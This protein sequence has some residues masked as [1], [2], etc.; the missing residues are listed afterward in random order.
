MRGTQAPDE[1]PLTDADRTLKVPVLGICG[2]EQ[3]INISLGG[4]L[5]QDIKCLEFETLEHEQLNPRN[6]T[7]HQI[8]IEPKT[9]LH[10]IIGENEISVNSAHHQAIDKLGN[11]LIMSS[12]SKDGIIESIE[13]SIHK[14][15]VGL[16]WHPEFLITKADKLIF[17][18]FIYN[19]V[20]K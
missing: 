10:K 2:G 4:T 17:L 12:M 13:S 8:Y 7:S 9:L 5:I 16:Q 6:Q 18:D 14:W 19:S 11:N 1:D 20:K 15:C 3:L